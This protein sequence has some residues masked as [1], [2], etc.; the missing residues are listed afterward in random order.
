MYFFFLRH[1][2]A[3]V[4]LR[5]KRKT[6][7][8][9]ITGKRYKQ[10]LLSSIEYYIRPPSKETASHCQIYVAPGN[11]QPI[12]ILRIFA[13]TNSGTYFFYSNVGLTRCATTSSKIIFRR[14]WLTLRR[15]SILMGN[16]CSIQRTLFE[17]T[18]HYN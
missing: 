5:H 12:S 13:G 1:L 17:S 11:F 10:H 4:V 6:A 9:N 2:Q 8:D 18:K 14:L 16:R 7:C 3:I 15:L